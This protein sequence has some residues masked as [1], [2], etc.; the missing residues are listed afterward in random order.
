MPGWYAENINLQSVLDSNP[1]LKT[2]FETGQTNIAR[3][4]YIYLPEE[5]MDSIY[6]ILKGKIKLG[7]YRNA[8][9]E[10]ITA[11]LYEGDVFSE[12]SILGNHTRNDFAMAMENAIV[13][14]F[15]QEKLKTIMADFPEFSVLM[16]KIMGERV[17]EMHERLES[18]IFMD[19]Q[20]RIIDF[21]VRS[22]EKR[23][24]RMGYEWILRNFYTHQDIANLTSTSRQSVTMILNKL[25][26]DNIIQ[27]DRKRMLIR[28]LDKLKSLIK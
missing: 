25:R 22:V 10:V 28:D 20:S 16:M 19:S 1:A 8:E 12:L 27:F 5:K 3:G 17:T 15:T 18:L 24:Q 7:T 26:K 14:G 9:T 11:I 4:D 6:F 13:V 21:L 23:G 2:L